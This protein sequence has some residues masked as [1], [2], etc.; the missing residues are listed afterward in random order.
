MTKPDREI[1][2]ILAAFDL[3]RSARSA[4][5]LAGCDPKTVQRYVERR[6]GGSSPFE[7]ARRPRLI[8]PFLE[9]IEELVERSNGRI[10][11]DVV[12]DAHIVP[13]GFV[14]DERTTRRAVAAAKAAWAEGRRRTYRPWVPEPGMWAQYDWGKGPEVCGRATCLFCGW[15]AWSRF[16]W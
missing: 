2:E 3:T 8:D 7:P 11:A 5:K 13:M 9:K 14:G 10:R 6:D 12:H 16:R 15:L 4:A 1:M